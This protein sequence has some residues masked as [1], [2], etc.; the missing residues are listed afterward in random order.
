[1]APRRQPPRTRTSNPPPP[2]PMPT[3]EAELNALIGERVSQAI[4][5]YEASRAE[6]SGGTGGSGGPGHGG[7]YGGTN[8]NGNT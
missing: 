2:P 5:L 6:H 4:A 3:N 1:M 8:T 7:T